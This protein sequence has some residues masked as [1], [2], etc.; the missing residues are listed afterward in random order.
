VARNDNGNNLYLDNIELF[1][2]D[3]SN[4]PVTTVPYQLYYSSRY[5]ESDIALTM[6]LDK[7]Q[8]VHL[9]II[10]IQGNLIAE[11]MLTDALNQTYYFDLSQQP[12]GLYISG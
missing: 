2:G 6:N 12:S 7:R 5:P 11:H 10:G 3:D 1:V 8:D 9:Q 4:P